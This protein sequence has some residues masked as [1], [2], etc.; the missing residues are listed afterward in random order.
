MNT[1]ASR[2]SAVSASSSDP[3]ARGGRWWNGPFAAAGVL[4]LFWV[5]LQASLRD[6][7]IAFDEIAQAAAGY[8][9]WQF[10]DYRIDPPNGNLP[11]RLMTLP[12]LDARFTFP[13]RDS[14]MWQE[15]DAWRLGDAWFN[16]SSNDPQAMLARGHA[17]MGLVAVALGALVWCQARRLFGATAGMIALLL[18]VLDPTVLAHGALM[19]SDM[20]AAFFF[21]AATL[22][23][24]AVLERV[25]WWTVALSSVATAGLFLAKM[26]APLIL[27]VAAVLV[28]LRLASAR[29]LTV[30]CGR[31]RE[32]RHRLQRALVLSGVAGIHVAVAWAAVWAFYGFRF[33]AFAQR[34][35]GRLSYPWSYI[36]DQPGPTKLIDRLQ[37]SREQQEQLQ[38]LPDA[39]SLT[40]D[41]WSWDGE[42]A[43]S[44]LERDVLTPAQRANLAALRAAPPPALTARV[45][46]F[47][48]RHELLP[49]SF[50]FGY[51]HG[52]LFSRERIAFLNGEVRLQGW[53]GY[54]PYTFL[55]KTPLAVFALLALAGCVA[56]RT[57]AWTGA[58]LPL[59]TLLAVYWAAAVT[60]HINIGHRHLLPVYAPLYVLA[61]AA[62]CLPWARVASGGLVLAVGAEMAARF[63]NYLAYFNGIVRPAAAYTHLVDS[64]LDWGQEL[65]AVKR[66]VDARPAG[67]RIYLSYFGTGDPARYGIRATA[68]FS[69]PG[70]F[71]RDE[72]LLLAHTK[73]GTA[74]DVAQ[75]WPEHEIV[76]IA[77]DGDDRVLLLLKKPEALRLAAGS[78]LISATMLQPLYYKPWGP[79]NAR[80]ESEYQAL[81]QAVKPLLS[82]DPAARAAALQ[83]RDPEDW[84]L[85]LRRFEEIRFARLAAFL[86]QRKPD[87]EINFG[88]LVFH[89]SDADIARALDGP[90]PELGEDLPKKLSAPRPAS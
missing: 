21:L 2:A 82:T 5:L 53:R 38:R 13:A 72:S 51:A 4:L 20:T 16:A 68:L 81:A 80:Y 70:L 78:Y 17:I 48:R 62:A 15:S 85:M 28:A 11:K 52:W 18:F 47:C 27:L 44:R 32:V 31:S 55:V 86:R 43:L 23:I 36:L 89:L 88:V 24:A 1:P 25:T 9:Y 56:W 79:W 83:Q 30:L 26:S 54:F 33:S 61:G 29:P 77:D 6:K 66:W 34:D 19:T 75:R 8:T 64:S 10:D 74:V 37:L 84:K 87:E 50:L 49:E 35:G 65:P 3:R 63:P 71:I 39:P 40:L 12:L 14:E 22:A 73:R 45:I 57:R 59:W 76:G 41:E 42:D 69:E 58:T 90:P 7:S 46:D 60:S 67:E